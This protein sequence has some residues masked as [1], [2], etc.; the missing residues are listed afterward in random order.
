[1]NI[2]SMQQRSVTSL[3]FMDATY[4]LFCSSNWTLVDLKGSS[5]GKA[6]LKL[7]EE[8]YIHSLSVCY[9]FNKDTIALHSVPALA[10]SVQCCN[11]E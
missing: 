7:T 5:K 1:M 4:I 9:V 3:R 6:Y 11:G 10:L 2:L 8:F